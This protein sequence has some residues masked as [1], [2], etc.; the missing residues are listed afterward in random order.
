M[1]KLATAV[2]LLFSSATAWAQQAP[3]V[4]P[5][6]AGSTAQPSTPSQTQGDAIEL[7]PVANLLQSEN[8][9]VAFLPIEKSKDS[10]AFMVS[11]SGKIGTIPMARL[12]DAAKAGY[13]PFTVAD[14]L[15]IANAVADEEKNLGKRFKELSEDYDALAA[16]YNRL[17][18]VNA[19]APV[20]P[21]PAVDERQAMRAM[22]F[23]ALL[24][25]AFPPPATRIQVET[26]DCTKFP[27]LCVNH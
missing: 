20:Q 18:A 8:Y 17:A 3:P 9:A 25:R 21:Q 13:R 6:G 5:Q 12:G 19:A 26:V 22:A 2:L 10:F 24:Q 14:L 4:A 27:A 1:K 16:R 23:R 11:P 15:A 7:A